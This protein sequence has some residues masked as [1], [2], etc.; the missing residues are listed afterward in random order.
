MSVRITAHGVADVA[1][2]G[3]EWRALEARAGRAS[4]FQGWTWMGCLAEERFPNPIVLRAE[5]GDGTTLGLA[6]FNRRRGG[7]YLSEAGDGRLDLPFVEHNAPLIDEQA[8]PGLLPA[9]M[10]AAWAAGGIFRMVLGGVP[11][12]VATAAGGWAWRRQERA[13]PRVDLEAVRGSGG[14]YLSCLS[15]NTRQQIRRS[16]RAYA[17]HGAMQADRAAS[18]AEALDWLDE[19]AALHG[20]MWRARGMPGAF[21]DPFML[22]FHRCLIER[23]VMREEVDLLRVRAG[24]RVIGYLLNLR[25]GGW[26]CAYQSGWDLAAA[27]KHERPGIVCHVLAIEQALRRGDSAYDFLAGEDR[28]KRSLGTDETTLVWQQSLEPPGPPGRPLPHRCLADSAASIRI[29]PRNASTSL[30]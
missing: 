12:A 7:L 27:G 3:A 22:R 18:V 6:L 1:S 19:L 15:A 9:M 26:V 30:V 21:A 4:I 24:E 17:A 29:A 25:R 13:A 11:P 28:Y 16:F 20:R 14:D 2:L 10:Q 23:G 8:A 5:A